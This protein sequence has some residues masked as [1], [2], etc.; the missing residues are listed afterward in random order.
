MCLQFTGKT[1]AKIIKLSPINGLEPASHEKG[2]MAISN[3]LRPRGIFERDRCVSGWS[4]ICD[5]ST[6]PVKGSQDGVRA[7]ENR[8]L[9]STSVIYVT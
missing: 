3:R 8:M 4:Y 7:L 9:A 6:N 1:I 2:R 5:H